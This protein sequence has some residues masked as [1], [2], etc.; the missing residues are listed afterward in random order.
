[1]YRVFHQRMR[2][3]RPRDKYQIFIFNFNSISSPYSPS[4]LS[5][6][7]TNTSRHQT[8]IRMTHPRRVKKKKKKTRIPSHRNA[9]E[10][11]IAT[12]A[13]NRV[14]SKH[15]SHIL[16][17]LLLLPLLLPPPA[18]KSPQAALLREEAAHDPLVSISKVFRPCPGGNIDPHS[19][20]FITFCFRQ[21]V[22]C[23]PL[24]HSLHSF[25]FSAPVIGAKNGREK[26]GDTMPLFFFFLFNNQRHFFVHHDYRLDAR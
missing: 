10:K 8:R 14:H 12:I 4:P 11:G 17:F 9:F 19:I 24:L 5:F 22:T 25:P 13:K 2:R 21:S 18:D 26:N 3:P 16:P 7:L 20:P 15:P 1:M 23:P 6:R